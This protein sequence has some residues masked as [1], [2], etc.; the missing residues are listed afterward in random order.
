MV[1]IGEKWSGQI[2]A[3]CST[4]FP[5]CHIMIRKNVLDLFDRVEGE[6]RKEIHVPWLFTL[7]YVVFS[8]V[9]VSFPYGVLGLILFIPV[10]CLHSYFKVHRIASK[11]VY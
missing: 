2:L 3:V 11:S 9:L 8:C 10:L 7:L 4:L 1:A 5:L 6:L